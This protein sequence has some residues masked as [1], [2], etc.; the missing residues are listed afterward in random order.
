MSQAPTARPVGLRERKKAATREAIH[1]AALRL[2][3]ERGLAGVTVEEICAEADIA[4]RTFFNYYPTKVAAVFDLR[5]E[6]IPESEQEAFATASGNVVEDACA[7]V[8]PHVHVPS[9][10]RRIKELMGDQ[11]DLR[12]E[13]WLQ[14]IC[15]VK[16]LFPLLE[17]RTGD[18]HRSRVTM[19]L[20]I[21]AISAAIM[22]A[23]GAA[24]DSLPARLTA[25]LDTMRGLLGQS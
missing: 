24:A 25:E 5:T 20:V 19:G 11:P 9:D 10:F 2:G 3:A 17:R 6:P 21:A 8:A 1:E 12:Q 16:P 7:L 18:P 23:D 22:R 14:L 15:V 13:F 4:P